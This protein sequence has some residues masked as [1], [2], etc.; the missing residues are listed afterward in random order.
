M[1]NI[2]VSTTDPLRQLDLEI[3]ARVFEFPLKKVFHPTWD[4]E[5]ELFYFIPSGKP[6]RTHE[7]DSR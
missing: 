7:I 5:Q 4:I 2:E 3:L 1:A 6:R